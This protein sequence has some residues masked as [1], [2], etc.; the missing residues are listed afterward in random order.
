MTVLSV[1]THNAN[2]PTN[3]IGTTIFLSYIAAALY[4]TFS[5]TLS[6]NRQY[7]SI[8]TSA[9]KKNEAEHTIKARARSIKI[10]SVLAGT[11]FATLSWHMLNFLIASYLQWN[12]RKHLSQAELS[13]DTLKRWMLESTLFQDFARELVNNRASAAWTQVAILGSWFWGV[14]TAR[15]GKSFA[16]VIICDI[17]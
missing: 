1:F 15:E 16:L 7:T 10:F 6:L 12:D 17:A 3:Y 14:W 9:S 13:G 11:S 2:P 8:S 4:L 5:I